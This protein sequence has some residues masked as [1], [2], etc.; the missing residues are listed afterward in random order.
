MIT[1]VGRTEGERK[2]S[3]NS[4]DRAEYKEAFALFDKKGTG[5]I[6]R[7]VLGDLLR[8]LGQNPTQAEVADIVSKAP[9]EGK[10]LPYFFGYPLRN[11][12]ITC[13]TYSGLQELFDDFEPS[14]WVQTCR[15]TWCVNSVLQS[16]TGASLTSP[17]L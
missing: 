10:V 14:R 11:L 16:T 5:A 7:E 6:P 4:W 15:Y 1:P 2:T 13:G 9:R 3:A 12:L 8:A 17:G